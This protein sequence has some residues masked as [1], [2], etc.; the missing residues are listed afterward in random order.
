MPAPDYTK[1]TL[2]TLNEGAAEELFQHEFDLVLKNIADPNMPASGT[3]KITLEFTIRPT[4]DRCH[5]HIGLVCTSKLAS[6]K[7]VE[8]LSTL[9][10]FGNQLEA[11]Q[12][13]RK[14]GD[15][16]SEPHQNNISKLKA[17]K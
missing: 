8:K 17:A 2:S 11:Y 1:V 9:N 14:D 6:V 16:F 12:D 3:R 15:L 5:A 13:V 7:P 10:L 4:E